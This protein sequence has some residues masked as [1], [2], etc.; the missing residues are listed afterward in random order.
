MRTIG[1]PFTGAAAFVK[2]DL[3]VEG[4]NLAGQLRP[5]LEEAS[6]YPPAPPGRL[7]AVEIGQPGVLAMTS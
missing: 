1:R 5:R 3:V 4:Y 6:S 7:P 2:F